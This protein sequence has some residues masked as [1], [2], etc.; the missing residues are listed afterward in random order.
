MSTSAVVVWGVLPSFVCRRTRYVLWLLA[1]LLVSFS[2]LVPFRGPLVAPC[3]R[4]VLVPFSPWCGAWL[5]FDVSL[6]RE[7]FIVEYY[8][9]DDLRP[10]VIELV[11]SLSRCWRHLGCPW[12]LEHS[13]RLLLVVHQAPGSETFY[14]EFFGTGHASGTPAR[15]YELSPA[16]VDYS[17]FSV[18][19][20]GVPPPLPWLDAVPLSAAAS[21]CVEAPSAAS[22]AATTVSTA[23]SVTGGADSVSS[24]GG[25][26]H[27]RPPGS[28]GSPPRRRRTGACSHTAVSEAYF[29]SDESE[30]FSP[31]SGYV[32]S[33][34]PA[35]VDL[36]KVDS[37]DLPDLMSVVERRK[38]ASG[39]PSPSP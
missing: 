15:P 23:S 9:V 37:L 11:L 24:P 28:S 12:L 3:E 7:A 14:Y 1:W 27:P 31:V 34:E 25:S 32:A 17:A 38:L 39:R 21:S 5:P 8:Y 22:R 36:H 35:A 10:P 13:A 26:P 30:D 29:F 20:A 2:S 33:D 4:R 19:F 18:L 16:R 6:Q